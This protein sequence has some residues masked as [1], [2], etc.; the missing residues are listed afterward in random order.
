[1]TRH[2][3]PTPA[4]LVDVPALDRNIARMARFFAGLPCKLRPHF[5]AHKTPEIARRQ[6]AAGSCTGITCATV[7]EAE[8]VAEVCN[9]LLIANE[10]I[11]EAKCARVAALASRVT[12]TIAIDSPAG[13]AHIGEAAIK[14][15]TT[16]GVLIDVNVGQERCGMKPGEDALALARVAAATPGVSLRGVMGYEGHL[17]P[18]PDR[19][20]R[21]QL[22]LAAMRELTTTADLLRS[23][24]L[25]CDIVSAGGTG[26]FDISGRVPGV[27]EIQAGSY[28][29]MDTDYGR[30]DLPFEPA[31]SVLGTIVSRPTADRCVAD[32]GHKS[33]TKDHGLPAVKTIP[34]ATVTSLND[35]H[36][37]ISLPLGASISIG[38]RVELLPSHTDPTV[39]LHDVFYAMDGDEVVGV[40]PI[41]AR[42]YRVP[43]RLV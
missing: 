9:D 12:V 30:L 17:Q 42:G 26:T 8:I 11:G 20:E 2:D 16:V 13:L 25:T 28:A 21:A 7:S 23:A 14:A 41:A 39:N 31:F 15:G 24:G 10:I 29:L 5:K 32:C 43:E 6:L 36:A 34:G 35:E 18:V 22:A 19:S 38:D 3:I 37:V 27:T 33:M 40:W 1:M 4:L